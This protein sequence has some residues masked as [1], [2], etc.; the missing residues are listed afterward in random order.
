MLGGP[1][2]RRGQPGATVQLAGVASAALPL[3][4]RE[5]QVA[6]EPTPFAILVEPGEQARP[7]PQ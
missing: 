5:R 2:E 1:V 6:V 3:A 4:S 7:F